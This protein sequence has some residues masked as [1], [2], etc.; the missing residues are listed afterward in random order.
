LKSIETSG[1]VEYCMMPSARRW[2]PVSKRRVEFP[3]RWFL[4]VHER[5]R[6]IPPPDTFGVGTRM[7]KARRSLPLEPRQHLSHGGRRAGAGG[8]SWTG[9]A[10]RRAPEILVRQ[11]EQLL[12]VRVGMNG[13][14]SIL[15]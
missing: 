5:P 11:V 8:D 2:T 7:A 4:F 13:W 15:F 9:A 6:E 3:A 12:V 1:S 10:A 14:S